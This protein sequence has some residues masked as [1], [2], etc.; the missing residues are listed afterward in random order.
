MAPIARINFCNTSPAAYTGGNMAHRNSR[1]L[2]VLTALMATTFSAVA[3]HGSNVSYHT[4]QTMT[5]AGDVLQK[6]VNESD[7]LQYIP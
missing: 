6:P 4:D 5:I 2:S 3:H 1:I 7:R